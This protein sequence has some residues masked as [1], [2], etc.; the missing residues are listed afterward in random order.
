MRRRWTGPGEKLHPRLHPL[1]CPLQRPDNLTE[2][3]RAARDNLPQRSDNLTGRSDKLS[4]QG[5]QNDRTLKTPDSSLPK[6]SSPD[7]SDFSLTLFEEK[8]EEK[9]AE[10]KKAEEKKAEPD[11]ASTLP[12]WPSLPEAEQRSWLDQARQELAGDPR[13]QRHHPEAQAGGGAGEEPVRGIAE[14]KSL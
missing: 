8:T 5:G 9:K 7:V 13:R 12:S 11:K 3:S 14:G 4:D 1:T 2:R 10:E 6:H